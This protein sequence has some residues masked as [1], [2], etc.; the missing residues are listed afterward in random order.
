[1]NI[2]NHVHWLIIILLFGLGAGT[3]VLAESNPDNDSKVKTNGMITKDLHSIDVLHK[4]KKVTI[5]RSTDGNAVIPPT[6]AKVARDCPPFCVAPMSLGQ[7]IETIGELE[8]LSY[9]KSIS[10]GDKSVLVVDSRTPEWVSKGTIP[11][12]VNIPWTKIN[13]D[14]K[15]TKAIDINTILANDFGVIIKDVTAFGKLINK[16]NLYFWDAKTV[17]FF[18]NGAWCPQSATNVSTLAKLGYPTRKLKWYRGGMQS[19]TSLGLTTV[20]E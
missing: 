5:K 6:Y 12:S 13:I 9:L 20:S 1:M 16:D 15:G 14:I 11:G 18:C 4:G 3:N 2:K 19:W 10:D 17:V 8:V 7:G